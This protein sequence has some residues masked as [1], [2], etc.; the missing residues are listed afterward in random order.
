VD[1]DA[2]Q[3][4]LNQMLEWAARWEMEFNNQKCKVMH[5][6]SRNGRHVYNMDGHVLDVTEEE[7]DVG[8]LVTSNLKP[9]RQC[10]KAAQTVSVVLGQ[11]SCSFN[12]RDQKVFPA[13]YKRYVRPHMEFSC[14]AWSPWYH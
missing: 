11:I 13:L 5:F 8:V 6:G 14:P 10:A 12:Y 9:A 3:N 4:A 1:C 2:L 7:R